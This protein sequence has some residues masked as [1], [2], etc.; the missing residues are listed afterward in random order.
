ML[1]RMRTIRTCKYDTGL[2]AA[3]TAVGGPSALAGKLGIGASAVTQWRSI[4]QRH[5]RTIADATGLTLDQ[6]VPATPRPAPEQGA[7]A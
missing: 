6:L 1:I 5:L 4:P 7:A 2:Q 3:L